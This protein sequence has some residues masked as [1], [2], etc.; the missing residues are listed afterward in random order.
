MSRATLEKALKRLRSEVNALEAE[1]APVKD[2]L[3]GLIADVEHQIENLD[4]RSHRRGLVGR[5]RDFIGEHEAEHPAITEA[6]NRIM[7]T[8]SSMGI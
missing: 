4:D 1:Q 7:D 8:L 5:L 3:T 6:L 2:R